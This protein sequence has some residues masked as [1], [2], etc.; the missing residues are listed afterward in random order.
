MIVR[1]AAEGASA[2]DVGLDLEFLMK[3][4]K[5]IQAQAKASKPPALIFQE[6][7]LPLRVTRDLFTGDFERALVDD[8]RTLKRIRAT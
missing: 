3:L 4:W 8:D 6:A 1:T 5:Q 2:D 7:E